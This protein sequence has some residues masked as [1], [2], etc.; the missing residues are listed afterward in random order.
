MH[1][2]SLYSGLFLTAVLWILKRLIEQEISFAYWFERIGL[3]T[4]TPTQE[5]TYFYS[6]AQQDKGRINSA[7]R[8]SRDGTSIVDALLYGLL[9]IVGKGY[10]VIISAYLELKPSTV[11]IF[12]VAV[13]WLNV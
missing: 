9:G 7:V 2:W 13:V 12:D 4:T 11:S 10:Q 5:N 1:T 8:S 6:H 3:F